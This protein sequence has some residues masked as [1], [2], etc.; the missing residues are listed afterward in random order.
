MSVVLG[1]W[2]VVKWL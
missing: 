2:S 1:L